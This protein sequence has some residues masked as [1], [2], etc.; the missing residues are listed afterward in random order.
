MEQQKKR[1]AI[2]IIR[3]RVQML[4]RLETLELKEASLLDELIKTQAEIR[5]LNR[6]FKLMAKEDKDDEKKVKEPEAER[7]NIRE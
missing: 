3:R 2:E 6:D 5:Q 1:E 4:H 7:D